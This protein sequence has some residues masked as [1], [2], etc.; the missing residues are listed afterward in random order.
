MICF[1]EDESGMGGDKS[2]L[3]VSALFSNSMPECHNLR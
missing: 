2:N 1:Q 3:T